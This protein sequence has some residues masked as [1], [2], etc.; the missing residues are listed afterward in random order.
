MTGTYALHILVG[1]LGIVSGFLALY[2]TKGARLHKKSG[3]VFVYVMVT[4][5]L[6]GMIMAVALG[7]APEV[8]VPAG[9]LTAYLI[10]TALATVRP[11]F[12]GSRGLLIAGMLVGFG[13]AAANLVL[14]ART[15]AGPAATRGFAFPFFMFAVVGGLGGAGDLR[16][17]RLGPPRGAH[18]LAR[19][20]WRMCFALF[21]AALSFFIGQADVFPP[22]IRIRPL[23]GL[24]VFLVLVTMF[25]WLWRV[26]IRQSLRGVVESGRLG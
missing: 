21:I 3:R 4:T 15:L 19:H 8:N 2:T 18:R 14:G 16:V 26:R 24:P 1:G 20:L 17:L 23:L 12:A 5:A 11:P 7:V 22:P 13:V 6:T 9:L 25:Y 10:V